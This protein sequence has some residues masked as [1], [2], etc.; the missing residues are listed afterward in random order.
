MEFKGHFQY[1]LSAKL[2]FC[3]LNLLGKV[4]SKFPVLGSV[5]LCLFTLW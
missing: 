3:D 5:L 2:M 4:F 1:I